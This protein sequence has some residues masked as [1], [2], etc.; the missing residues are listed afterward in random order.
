MS[1]LNG[2]EFKEQKGGDAVLPKE[3]GTS[4][5]G[6]PSATAAKTVGGSHKKDGQMGGSHTAKTNSQM[7]GK[8][9][10]STRKSRK[11]HRKSGKKSM[12]KSMKKMMGKMWK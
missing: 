6:N 11:H 5:G 10:K 3:A 9:R 2:S 8:K 1:T 4:T 7:G 12:M